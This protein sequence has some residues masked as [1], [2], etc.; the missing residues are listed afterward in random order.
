MNSELR[1]F[2]AGDRAVLAVLGEEI[3]EEVNDRVRALYQAVCRAEA[4][5]IVEAV[6]SY[7]SVLVHYRPELVSYAEMEAYLSSLAVRPADADAVQ[8]RTLVVPVCYGLHFGPDLWEMEKVLGLSRQEIIGIHSGRDYRIYMMGFLPGFVYLGGMDERLSYPRLKKPRL[9]IEAGSVGIAGGQTGIYPGVSPGGWR[10]IGNT[11]IRMF[12]PSLEPPVPVGAGDRIRFQPIS[13]DEWYEIRH[14]VQKGQYEPQVLGGEPSVRRRTDSPA[15]I[16]S[17]QTLCLKVLSAGPLS[18]VQDGGRFGSQAG[19]VTESGAMDR[20]SLRLANRLLGNEENAAALELTLFGGSFVFEGAGEIALTGA[21][22]HPLLNG[23]P[24]PMTEAIPVRSGD[25]LDLGPA[26]RGVRAYLAVAGGID[27]P[28]VL[29]SR[30]TDLKAG[31]GGFEGRKLRSGDVLLALPRKSAEKEHA[32]PASARPVLQ[33]LREASDAD[34]VTAIRFRFGPQ[35]S[36]FS[37]EAKG[38]FTRN[39]YTVGAAN[40]R[41]GYRLE[42]PAVETAGGTDILSD[43]ICF[44]SIQIPADGRPIVMMADHQTTGGYAKIGTVLSGDLPLLAQLGPGK[45]IRFEEE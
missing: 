31:I 44:G 14:L 37:A 34:G 17:G 30:S 45:K 18:T 29:G 22:M 4:P 3:S 8:P 33:R 7:T 12:D 40:D 32:A 28:V 25:R 38:Q 43:G 42:G 13:V 19:G 2:P 41:M 39:V 6:P 35:D 23:E 26:V 27:V 11:P 20:D 36:R 16:C 21:E 24:V 5:Q 15:A 1:F 9:R 10:I